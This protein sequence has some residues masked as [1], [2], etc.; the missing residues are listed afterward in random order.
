MWRK[1]RRGIAREQLDRRRFSEADIRPA[2][3]VRPGPGF[4]LWVV[5]DTHDNQELIVSAGSVARSLRP[6]GDGAARLATRARVGT[7]SSLRLRLGI[8]APRSS[9]S[10]RWWVPARTRSAWW[11][12]IPTPCRPDLSLPR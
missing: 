6:A 3:V 5:H 2:H 1:P 8:S 12:P 10:P 11:K 7:P 4:G 9:P